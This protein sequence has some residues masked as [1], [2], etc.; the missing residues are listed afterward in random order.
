MLRLFP[1]R[2]SG[3]AVVA[4]LSPMGAMVFEKS[5]RV[6][7]HPGQFL[8]RAVGCPGRI[9]TGIPGGRRAA[10]QRC[11]HM[12][13]GS[14]SAVRC[15]PVSS[16]PLPRRMRWSDRM[17][18][19]RRV[20][21]PCRGRTGGVLRRPVSQLEWD[22]GPAPDHPTRRGRTRALPFLPPV[23]I[24]GDRLP[25]RRRRFGGTTPSGVQQLSRAFHDG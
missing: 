3:M 10:V 4:R 5:V 23:N 15:S 8:R 11:V 12:P 16:S 6:I 13:L 21:P 14:S 2:L 18:T 17:F 24:P 9:P 20:P 7:E 1:L 22:Q 25:H 19:P